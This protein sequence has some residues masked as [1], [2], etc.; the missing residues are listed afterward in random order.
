MTAGSSMGMGSRGQQLLLSLGRWL[1]RTMTGEDLP[2]GE[3]FRRFQAV[4][5]ANNR[6]LELMAE[7]WERLAGDSI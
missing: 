3:V 7:M 2:V 6:A 1:A 4:L 5:A